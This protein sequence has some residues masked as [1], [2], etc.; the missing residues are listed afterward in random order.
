MPTVSNGQPVVET[1]SR[2]ELQNLVSDIKETLSS[3]EPKEAPT[4]RG[5]ISSLIG[6]T[7]KT[8]TLGTKLE[9]LERDVLNS[10]LTKTELK[11]DLKSAID[12]FKKAPAHEYS[13]TS[14]DLQG[15]DPIKE[16][17]DDLRAFRNRV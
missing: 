13:S 9:K 12:E 14:V 5:I 3:I 7:S 1:R 2:T 4:K 6:G 16:I 11:S 15:Q 17:I 10:N 8:N